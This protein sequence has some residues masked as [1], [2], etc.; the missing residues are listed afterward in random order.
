M[1][2]FANM[3]ERN[4][5]RDVR[6]HFH[7][8]IL[9]ICFQFANTFVEKVK[10]EVS[11]WGKS[12][13]ALTTSHS[14]LIIIWYSGANLV[15]D[16]Y[17]C[18]VEATRIAATVIIFIEHRW[19]IMWFLMLAIGHRPLFNFSIH[20]QEAVF[21]LIL[22]TD[23]RLHQ[24]T[25]CILYTTH[26]RQLIAFRMIVIIV[27]TS[28]YFIC[29]INDI[30]ESGIRGNSQARQECCAYVYFKEYLKGDTLWKFDQNV[31]RFV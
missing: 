11:V 30:D 1:T 24:Y 14:I 8:I 3:R 23:L 10:C 15:R 31:T 27:Q 25:L 5:I 17:R 28:I 4:V 6:K 20:I 7:L 19:V 2:T 29:N 13:N 22:H 12:F 18:F 26:L 9:L 21:S 16:D